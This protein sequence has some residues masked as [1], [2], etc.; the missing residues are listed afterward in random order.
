MGCLR[1][2]PGATKSGG[3][4]GVKEVP[5]ADTAPSRKPLGKKPVEEKDDVRNQVHVAP[6]EEAKMLEQ[7]ITLAEDVYYATEED[8]QVFSES[9]WWKLGLTSS[10][11]HQISKIRLRGIDQ[12]IIRAQTL[13]QD[14]PAMLLLLRRPGC[15][16]FYASYLVLALVPAI[17][18]K[19]IE[20]VSGFCRDS[21]LTNRIL[22]STAS[23]SSI[24]SFSVVR[25]QCCLGTSSSKGHADLVGCVQ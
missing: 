18:W 14:K 24:P 17:S 21:R 15:S 6:G 2:K 9:L 13:W 8:V 5:V 23:H 20:I 12:Q 3:E 25:C 4:P 16:A 1:P 10:C 19:A 11:I 7:V 22:W